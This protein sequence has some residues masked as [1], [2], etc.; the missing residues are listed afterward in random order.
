[1]SESR[2]IVFIAYDGV[3]LLDITGPLEVFATANQVGANY[4]VKIASAGGS[5]VIASSGTRLGTDLSFPALPRSIDSLM[6]PGTVERQASPAQD[7]LVGAIR[8]GAERSRRTVSVCAGAFLL[9]EAGLLEGRT[10]TTH[11]RFMDEFAS[12][13]PNVRIDRDAIFVQDG[14]TFTS[15]GVTA[16][17]DMTLALVEADH[18]PEL[19]RK[20]AREMVMFMQRPGGQA[21]FSARMAMPVI[22]SEPL[23]EVIDFI[24]TDPT[25]DL[26][27]EN[28]SS[29]AGFSVR[30]LTRV[31]R[32]ELNLTPAE[33]VEQV[34]VETAK[35][36]LETSEASLT[37]I[38]TQAGIGSEETLRRSFLRQ[39]GTTPGAYRQR[40]RTTVRQRED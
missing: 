23:R 22:A 37:S 7:D 35:G 10:A 29:R 19:A 24:T 16:G 9:A 36:L 32:R 31:F 26:R 21:Q 40:F 15:A 5:D 4:Q 38:A 14:Q 34:R 25:A 13:F 39:A 3:T 28:L 1:M 33:Y 8:R 17:I 11:W 2:T 20:V 27:L 12:R 18:G 6:V 30:H